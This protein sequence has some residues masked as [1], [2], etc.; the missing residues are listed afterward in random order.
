LA[1]KAGNNRVLQQTLSSKIQLLK[2]Q[3]DNKVDIGA[4]RKD[5]HLKKQKALINKKGL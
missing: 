1:F 2:R 3:M 5:I 4:I